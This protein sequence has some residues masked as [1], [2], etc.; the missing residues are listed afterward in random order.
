ML[1]TFTQEKTLESLETI[2][3]TATP[4]KL[5]SPTHSVNS[6]TVPYSVLAEYG[7]DGLIPD[8]T[9]LLCLT[10][11]AEAL[12]VTELIRDSFCKAAAPAKIES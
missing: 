10:L 12:A 8:N 9:S 6:P 1:E 2:P 7:V 11:A 4:E 3:P 5:V